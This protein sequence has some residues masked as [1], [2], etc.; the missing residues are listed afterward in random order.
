[1]YSRLCPSSGQVI[2]RLLLLDVL[3]SQ[4]YPSG[5]LDVLLSTHTNALVF[6]IVEPFASE[7]L[8][9]KYT[10]QGCS[11]TNKGVRIGVVRINQYTPVDALKLGVKSP[12]NAVK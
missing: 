5:E 11:A 6:A 10:W 3:E 9:K 8:V 12:P 1:M 2:L 7:A 4:G